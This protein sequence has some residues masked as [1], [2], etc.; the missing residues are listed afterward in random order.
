MASAKGR[1][2]SLKW[3]YDNAERIFAAGA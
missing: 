3:R 2:A 1:E